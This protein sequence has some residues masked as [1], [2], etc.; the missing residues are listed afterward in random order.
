MLV[1]VGGLKA[2]HCDIEVGLHDRCDVSLVHTEVERLDV[3]VVRQDAID[4]GLNEDVGDDCGEM[5]S[6][7]LLVLVERVRLLN[8]FHDFL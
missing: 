1:E 6:C 2:C 5:I 4:L 8:D 3:V 7:D